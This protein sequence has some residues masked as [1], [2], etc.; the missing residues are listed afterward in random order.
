MPTT[1]RPE[2]ELVFRSSEEKET[3][4]FGNLLSRFV[5]PGLLILLQGE[6]GAGKTVLV[7]GIA[8]GLSAGKVRSP[9][10]TLVNEYS[11]AIP[12]THADLYR[13]SPGGQDDLGLEEAL[14]EGR[15]VLVEW[16]EN[17]N[18]PPLEEAWICRIELPEPPDFAAT[19]KIRISSFGEKASSA[20][21]EAAVSILE[22]GDEKN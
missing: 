9:S 8:E 12:V 1:A 10:F 17:W 5:F 3:F 7:R 18:H 15:L 14:E 19:R 22:K 11:A 13:R 2:F 21:R 6:L 4:R 16:A 20:L